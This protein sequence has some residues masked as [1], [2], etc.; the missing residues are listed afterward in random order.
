MRG[1]RE[2]LGPLEQRGLSGRLVRLVRRGLLVRPVRRVLL[3]R[4]D[5][6]GWLIAEG[7]GR[8]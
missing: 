6:L 7:M 4:R 8:R 1:R 2:C 3:V 5:W